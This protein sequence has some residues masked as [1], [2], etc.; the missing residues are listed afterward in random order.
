MR[1]PQRFRNENDLMEA[2]TTIKTRAPPDSGYPATDT[3]LDRLD[4]C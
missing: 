3:R 4:T 2:M 1:R